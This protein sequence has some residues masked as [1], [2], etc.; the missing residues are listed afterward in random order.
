MRHVVQR[1]LAFFSTIRGKLI[2]IFTAIFGLS[3]IAATVISY[4]MFSASHEADFDASLYNHAIDVAS[5]LDG[6][7]FDL[8]FSPF[9]MIGSD[10]DAKKIPFPLR[11]SFLQVRRLDGTLVA[12]SRNLEEAILPLSRIQAVVL[13]S[14]G[15]VF[16]T[17]NAGSLPDSPGARTRHFRLINYIVRRGNLPLLILQI[18][19]PMTLVEQSQNRL[20]NLFMLLVPLALL[21]SAFTGYIIADKA[22]APIREMISRTAEIQIKNL[23][24]RVKVSEEDPELTSLATTLNEL[25]GRVEQAVHLQERFI[26]DASHQL[27]TPLAIIKGEMEI[28]LKDSEPGSRARDYLASVSGEVSQ[29]IRLVENLLLLAKMDAGHGMILFQKIR[30]DEIVMETVA[31]LKKLA[32]TKDIQ[33]TL[34]LVPHALPPLAAGETIDF[35]A[36]GDAELLRS[37]LV[38]LIENAIKYSEPGKTVSV[39][40]KETQS[41]FILEV[42]DQGVGLSPEE[43]PHIFERF[44][45]NLEQASRVAGSGLGLAIASRIVEVH[46]GEISVQSEK[47]RGSIFTAKMRKN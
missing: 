42:E 24:A 40:L 27:K 34:S 6:R 37:L 35:E 3:L 23:D 26:A 29:L 12:K 44:N 47:G 36:V 9:G 31:R 10:S 1:L 13:L 19:A 39:R 16:S 46:S 38:T 45:R 4:Q 25:L 28:L 22:F 32:A 30:L 7:P 17:L 33:L 5:T 2:A 43:I 15:V 8:P 18:A 11:R 14:Q 20:L 21:L 41:H